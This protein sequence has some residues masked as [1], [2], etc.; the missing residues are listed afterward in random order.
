MASLLSILVP[1]S[2]GDTTQRFRSG[3]CPVS[4]WELPNERGGDVCRNIRIRLALN[5][6][7]LGVTEALFDS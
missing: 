5:E 3:T 7:S 2:K 4:S 6:T 1:A